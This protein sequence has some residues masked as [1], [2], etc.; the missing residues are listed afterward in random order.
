MQIAW[1]CKKL[2][3]SVMLYN[4]Y[5]CTD[6]FEI[7]SLKVTLFCTD[8]FEISSRKVTLFCR[9]TFEISTRKVTLFK[10]TDT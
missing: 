10:C 8:T 7:S 6:T 9:D 3:M 5:V 4:L 2:L 1:T